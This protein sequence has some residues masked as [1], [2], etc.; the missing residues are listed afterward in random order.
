MTTQITLIAAVDQN[1]GIGK[2][3][4]LL[5]RSKE[6]LRRFKEATINN[7]VIMGRKTYQSIGAPLKD[8]TNI[9]LT[10]QDVA[11]PGVT[12]LYSKE[13]V[14]TVLREQ[15]KEPFKQ[16]A[17]VIGGGEIYRQF[18]DVA[19]RILLTRFNASALADTFFPNLGEEWVLTE[20]S[21]FNENPLLEM[22]FMTFI[23][24]RDTLP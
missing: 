15:E 7:I 22:D 5:F 16:E 21:H 24:K 11:F 3:G 9:V 4:N 12:T 17:F 23:R 6:D 20:T 13:A 14:L 10:T 1:N 19:D 18:L 2:D 8:R